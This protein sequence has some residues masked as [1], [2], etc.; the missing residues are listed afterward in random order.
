[1]AFLPGLLGATIPF[2]GRTLKGAVIGLG[3]GLERG[4]SAVDVLKETG[5]GALHGAI[6]QPDDERR[7]DPRPID[8][9]KAPEMKPK[10]PK[11][12]KHEGAKG[13]VK[14]PKLVK[15]KKKQRK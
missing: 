3:K 6:G 12:Q 4:D 5:L 7:V 10:H 9:E 13:K 15:H 11:P 2:L 8:M 1:M 14:L